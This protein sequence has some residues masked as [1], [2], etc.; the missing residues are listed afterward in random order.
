MT[1]EMGKSGNPAGKPKGARN[2]TTMAVER[3]RERCAKGGRAPRFSMFAAYDLEGDASAERPRYEDLA[4]RFGT[5]LYVY[6][7]VLEYVAQ[8]NVT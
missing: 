5:P 1:F 3:L 7:G 6:E 2:K 8:A 4:R